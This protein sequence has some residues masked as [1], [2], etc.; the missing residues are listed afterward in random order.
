MTGRLVR[1]TERGFL[2]HPLTV[3]LIAGSAF[4]L[5][6]FMTGQGTQ[7]EKVAQLESDVSELKDAERL[8]SGALVCL[9]RNNDALA[10]KTGTA[11]PCSISPGE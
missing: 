1:Q 10:A 4:G 3:A 9:T 8:R 7:T 6:G 2:E 11:L 5:L